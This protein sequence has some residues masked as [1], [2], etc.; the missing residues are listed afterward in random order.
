MSGWLSLQACVRRA[1]CFEAIG[2]GVITPA[3]RLATGSALGESAALVLAVAAVAAVWCAGFNRLFD[4]AMRRW[5]RRT[6][7]HEGP[8]VMLLRSALRE[9]TEIPVTLP[10]ICALSGMSLAG[11]LQA[12][13]ALAA[14]YVAYGYCFDMAEQKLRIFTSIAWPSRGRRDGG[15]KR[16]VGPVSLPA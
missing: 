7:G 10:V 13:L 8:S 6:P 9:V 4:G 3:Y 14:A 5:P 15:W 2:L 16:A 1:I 11:A 12:D